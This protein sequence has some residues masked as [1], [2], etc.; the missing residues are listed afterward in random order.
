[1]SLGIRI[2]ERPLRP[3]NEP[4]TLNFL[5]ST[6]WLACYLSFFTMAVILI[7][8]PIRDAN[9]ARLGNTVAPWDSTGS[10]ICFVVSLSGLTISYS[11]RPDQD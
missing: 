10:A 2:E 1:M 4:K 9:A 11:I 5:K 6:L 7:G 8:G 3:R